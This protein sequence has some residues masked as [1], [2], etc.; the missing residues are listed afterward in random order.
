[1][2]RNSQYARTRAAKWRVRPRQRAPL[3]ALTTRQRNGNTSGVSWSSQGF[4]AYNAGHGQSLGLNLRVVES[5][6]PSASEHAYN[7]SEVPGSTVGPGQTE[8]PASCGGVSQVRVAITDLS[9]RPSTVVVLGIHA[10]GHRLLESRG[11]IARVCTGGTAGAVG[12]CVGS[13]G[14]RPPGW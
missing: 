1:M 13:R 10:R 5:R 4:R 6:T 12:L 11:V 8:A 7:A 2:L 14:Y 3:S 9:M